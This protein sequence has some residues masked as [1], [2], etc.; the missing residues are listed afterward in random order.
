MLRNCRG[1]FLVELLLSLSIWMVMTVSLL[2]LYIHVSKQ[3]LDIQQ[4]VQATHLLYEVLQ[5]YVLE[6][7]AEDN[8]ITREKFVF[9]VI[10]EKESDGEPKRVCVN[11]EDAF[12]RAQQK[13]ER[14][15]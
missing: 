2:P 8:S 11:Y 10:W 15:K 4:E 7:V 1:F 6:A 5:R 13:C 9:A 12:Q 14:V 3:S